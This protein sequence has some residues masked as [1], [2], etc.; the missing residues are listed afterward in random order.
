MRE[1]RPIW[2]RIFVLLAILSVIF[3]LAMVVLGPLFFFVGITSAIKVVN[4][5]AALVALLSLEATMLQRFGEPDD[6]VFRGTMI[7]ISGLAASLILLI[8]SIYMIVQASKKLK[9]K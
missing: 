9:Q 2:N 8:M 6:G 1:K 3:M 5:T 7:G 4:L